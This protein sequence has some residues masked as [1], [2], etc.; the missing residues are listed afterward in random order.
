MPLHIAFTFVTIGA[1][2]LTVFGSCPASLA[3]LGYMVGLHI[4][5]V[6]MFFSSRA[7]YPFDARMPPTPFSG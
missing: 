6:K 7:N 2:H 1:K 5:Y 3:P 4:V